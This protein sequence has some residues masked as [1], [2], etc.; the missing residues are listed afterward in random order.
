M[1]RIGRPWNFYSMPGR[2][3]C[4]RGYRRWHWLPRAYPG[5]GHVTTTLYVWG[6]WS[7]EL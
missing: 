1:P 5:I 7:L 2:I 4:T 6:F 3:A